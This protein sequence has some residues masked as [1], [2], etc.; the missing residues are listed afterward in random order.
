MILLK[1]KPKHFIL[2]K[3]NIEAHG[4]FFNFIFLVSFYFQFDFGR[5]R[6]FLKE[7][8]F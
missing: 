4:I 3:L 2:S 7:Q 5:L 1:T 8:K 6:F